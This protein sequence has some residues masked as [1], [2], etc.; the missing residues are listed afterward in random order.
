MDILA[1]LVYQHTPFVGCKLDADESL[2]RMGLSSSTNPGTPVVAVTSSVHHK[3][4][5]LHQRV[6]VLI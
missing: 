1:R 5:I 6:I 4:G 2:A 3:D